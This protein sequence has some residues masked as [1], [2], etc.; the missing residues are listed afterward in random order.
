MGFVFLNFRKP[1]CN[2]QFRAKMDT[3]RLFEKIRQMASSFRFLKG[4]VFN[5]K[6]RPDYGFAKTP[7]LVI[8][9]KSPFDISFLA[10]F[11]FF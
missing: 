3:S 11:L 8:L 5:F 2:L 4:L 6:N 1:T 7:K 10:G 9:G